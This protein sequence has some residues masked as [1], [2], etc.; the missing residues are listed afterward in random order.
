MSRVFILYKSSLFARGLENLLR[1]EGAKVVGMALENGS[2]IDQISTL[3]P[4]LI[5]AEV[6][7]EKSKAEKLLK[8]LLR[9]E[10]AAK[11]VL[12]S[13]EDNT[14]A[15]YTGGRWTAHTAHDLLSGV[16]S[17]TSGMKTRRR[18]ASA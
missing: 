3:Q 14:V 5:I 9:E 11:V 7:R 17:S 18:R 1:G 6:D 15:L 16:V 13:L 2:A 4:D 8:K 12:I 10:V